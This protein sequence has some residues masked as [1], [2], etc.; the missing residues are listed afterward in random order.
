MR[1]NNPRYPNFQS[2]SYWNLPFLWVLF[3]SDRKK[4]NFFRRSE[5]NTS[6]RKGLSLLRKIQK[7]PRNFSKYICRLLWQKKKKSKNTK[8]KINN[9]NRVFFKK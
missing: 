9:L 8:N 5:L 6:F 4:M 1:T 2:N 3:I 7:N